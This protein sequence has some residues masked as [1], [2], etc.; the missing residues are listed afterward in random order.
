MKLFAEK[1]YN[2]LIMEIQYNLYFFIKLPRTQ[3]Y[4]V[5][6]IVRVATHLNNAT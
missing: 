5:Y 2:T 6:K 1:I 4:H 3:L